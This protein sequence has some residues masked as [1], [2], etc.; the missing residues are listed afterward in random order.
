MKGSRGLAVV[1]RR[2]LLALLA[3]CLLLL[4][5]TNLLV[6]GPQSAVLP[7]NGNAPQKQPLGIGVRIFLK[8]LF[9]DGYGQRCDRHAANRSVERQL[10]EATKFLDQRDPG[11][12]AYFFVET[13]CNGLVNARQACAVESAAL[14]HPDADVYLLL[15]SPPPEL[16]VRRQNPSVANLMDGYRNV[17]VLYFN[18]V[19]YFKGGPLEQWF[20]SGALRASNF[21]QSHTSD[22]FRYYT[23][24]KYG[25][26]YMD[27]DIILLRSLS[28]LTNF[29]GAESSEDIAAG[30]L[31]LER[32]STLAMECVREIRDH[33]RGDDWGANGPGVITRTVQKLCGTENT[34]EMTFDRCKGR[35]Q[36]MPPL[37]FYPIPWRQWRLYFN[38]SSS[39]DT[40]RRLSKSRAIHVWNKF[41]AATPVQV[42]SRQPY[43]LLAA[44]FCPRVYAGCGATF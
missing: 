7:E 14:L 31:N 25:G 44:K 38:I 12:A 2:H 26:T 32:H 28:A 3:L 24:W 8:R 4:L 42:G 37:D 19:D 18:L 9:G 10:P 30:V 13:S 34:Q 43:G 17:H 5:G 27:L 22:A 6:Q 36:V 33:F 20:R 21:E 41:S 15:L 23:L 29:A 1:S 16:D 39:N 40:M 35:F 11:R